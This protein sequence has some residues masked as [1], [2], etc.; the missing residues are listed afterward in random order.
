M[1]EESNN[2]RLL[3]VV[4]RGVSDVRALPPLETS[5]PSSSKVTSGELGV[6]F[7]E[8]ALGGGEPSIKVYDTTGPQGIDVRDGLP[9]RRAPWIAARASS[10]SQGVTQLSFARRGIITEEMRFVA[11][12]ENVDPELVRS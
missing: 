1:S 7:R 5:F 3:G 10:A 8:I 2:K 12:R 4:E 6:P 9:K 11:I